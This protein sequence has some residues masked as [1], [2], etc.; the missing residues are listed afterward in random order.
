MMY[1]RKSAL[2]I[3]KQ[4]RSAAQI[5]GHFS[6]YVLRSYGRWFIESLYSHDICILFE[7]RSGMIQA[8]KE[9]DWFFLM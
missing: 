3:E 2:S 6:R 5:S 1:N 4:V 8:T 7:S 9:N